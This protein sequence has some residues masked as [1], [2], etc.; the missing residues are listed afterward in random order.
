MRPL[1]LAAALAGQ[2][3]AIEPPLVA[4]DVGHFTL[5]PG[6]TSARGRSELEFNRALAALVAAA[7]ERRG[8]RARLIGY[9]GDM[10]VLSRRAAAAGGA[11]LLLSIH[12][13]SVQPHFL[14]EWTWEGERLRF[15]D[16][17]AGFSLFVSR[18]NP[19][20]GASL[21]CASAIGAS[22]RGAGFAPSLYHAE[23]IPGESKPFADR[24]NGVH[25][26][27]NLVVLHAATP[28]AVLFEAGVIVNRDEEL[29]LADPARQSRMADA[30]A[31]GVR[32]C[33]AARGRALTR[34]GPLG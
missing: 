22:L 34:R 28:P 16:R 7:L 15:S 18:R 12:H 11:D 8:V 5:A 13:D 31:D 27:D 21:A 20:L 24:A 32:S 29:R 30:V 9:D 10:S 17:Y 25:Y 23:P 19:A 4:V 14:E 26:Y 1:L 6:A 2:A 3:A 33:L